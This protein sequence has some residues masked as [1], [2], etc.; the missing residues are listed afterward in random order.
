MTKEEETMMFKQ[1]VEYANTFNKDFP[2]TEVKDENAHTVLALVKE[3]LDA[4][5]PYD[6]LTKTEIDG[7][8]AKAGAKK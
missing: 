5:K 4:G 6:E 8:K 1:L 7:A 2:I 3:C